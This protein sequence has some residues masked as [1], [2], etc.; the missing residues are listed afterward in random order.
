MSWGVRAAALLIVVGSP[1]SGQINP[2]PG[3]GDPHLQV[4][5]YV[6]GQIVQLHGAPG[7]QLM[8]E[9]SPDEQVQSVALGDSGAGKVRVTKAGDRLFL[10]PT[11]AGVATNMTVVTS[12]RVYA[13]D[14]LGVGAP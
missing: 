2:Q 14:L 8:I 6:D 3:G 4:V 5:D 1:I 12:V 10:K 11:Q 9:L 13:F 7:Y